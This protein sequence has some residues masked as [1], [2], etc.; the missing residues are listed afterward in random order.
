MRHHR[1]AAPVPGSAAFHAQRAVLLELVVD[2]PVA[3]DR[4]A[5]LPDRLGHPPHA[6]VDAV[7]A[8]AALGLVDRLD[9]VVRATTAAL[10]FEE[11]DLIRG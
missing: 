10:R 2:P 11:L 4:L 6:I 9:D 1:T 8:L 5:D 7:D 3:G